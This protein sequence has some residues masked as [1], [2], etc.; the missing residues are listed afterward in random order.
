MWTVEVL[1]SE[2]SSNN[3]EEKK[4]FLSGTEVCKIGRAN[5]CDISFVNDKS[6]S[7]YFYTSYNDQIYT[8]LCFRNH[9]ELY[10]NWLDPAD[11]NIHHTEN[12]T[13]TL[14]I[15]HR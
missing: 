6:I 10:V 1:A 14:S 13:N 15:N 12:A 5:D 7:R 4:Y 2:D 3:T 11:S 9:S 8:I